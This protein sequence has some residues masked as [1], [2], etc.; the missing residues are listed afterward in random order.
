[1]KLFCLADMDA[2]KGLD[3]MD[4]MDTC[5]LRYW[6]LVVGTARSWTKRDNVKG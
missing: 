3:G 1:M 5:L 4:G 2:S 6:Q